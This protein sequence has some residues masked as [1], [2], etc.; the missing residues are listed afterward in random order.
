MQIR[1]LRSASDLAAVEQLQREV[2]GFSDL[3]IVSGSSLRVMLEIGGVLVGV[4]DG[5]ELVAFNSGFVGY[6]HGHLEIHSDMLAVR[7]PYRDR[8]FGYTLKM[9]QRD[10]TLAMGIKRITWTFDPLR[11]RNAYFNFRKLGVVS[12]EYRVN[13][14]GESTSSFLHST[15]TDRLWVTWILDRPRV[16]VARMEEVVEIPREID[17]LSNEEQWTWRE[18]T[19]KRFSELIAAGYCVTDYDGNGRYTLQPGS[20]EEFAQ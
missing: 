15:G 13:F 14:Y 7:Q 8:G 20:L 9:A 4:F 17:S 2:W 18:S 1:D 10:R 12:N 5:D 19:R 6:R 16:P 11:S 3:D